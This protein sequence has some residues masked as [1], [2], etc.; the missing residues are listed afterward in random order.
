MSGSKGLVIIIHINALLLKQLASIECICDLTQEN[1]QILL[2]IAEEKRC[3]DMG[4][5]D[6]ENSQC[7]DKGYQLN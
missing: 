5:Q 2:R 3:M 4:N 1:P 7:G 6:K